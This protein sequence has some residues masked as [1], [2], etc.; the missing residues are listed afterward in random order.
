MDCAQLEYIAVAILE[1]EFLPTGNVID[2]A[3]FAMGK[4]PPKVHPVS[5]RDMDI[6]FNS[7]K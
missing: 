4:V 6:L 7:L 3:G 2:L 1:M 5:I